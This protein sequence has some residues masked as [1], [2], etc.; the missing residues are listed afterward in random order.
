MSLGPDCDAPV[1]AGAN[2]SDSEV[3]VKIINH[4]SGSFWF[5]AASGKVFRQ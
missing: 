2:W 5:N 4:K 3:G 1:G